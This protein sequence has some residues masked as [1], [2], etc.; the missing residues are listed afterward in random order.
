MPLK[1][2]CKGVCCDMNTIMAYKTVS[3]TEMISIK[4]DCQITKCSE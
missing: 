3:L 2:R 4:C 1:K